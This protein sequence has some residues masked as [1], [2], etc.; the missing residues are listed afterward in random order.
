MNYTYFARFNVL[1][2]TIMGLSTDKTYEDYNEAAQVIQGNRKPARAGFPV[3]Q[4]QIDLNSNLALNP[5]YLNTLIG[6]CK[7]KFW[8]IITSKLFFLNFKKL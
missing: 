6:L 2:S 1:E 7:K 8:S 5:G 3:P 4:T